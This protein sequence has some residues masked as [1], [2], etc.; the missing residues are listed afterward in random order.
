[1]SFASYIKKY[2]IQLKQDIEIYVESLLEETFNEV[3][4]LTPKVTGAPLIGTNAA[5]GLPAPDKCK[6]ERWAIPQQRLDGKW[7]FPKVP[8]EMIDQ[9]TDSQIDAFNNAFPYVFEEYSLD[10]FP[11]EEA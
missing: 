7:V 3:K 2:N 9:F 4:R 8:A 6:S 10:W 11:I 1:M 5:T